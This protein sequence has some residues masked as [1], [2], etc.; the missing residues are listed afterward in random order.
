MQDSLIGQTL[1]RYKIEKLIDEGGMARVYLAWRA[2]MKQ[3]VALKVLKT[4][5][6]QNE[7]MVSRFIR[8]A[9]AMAQL[10]HQ[11][12][13]PV[14]DAARAKSRYY[15]AMAYL[16][17]QDLKTRLARQFQSAGYG[18]TMAEALSATG[19]AAAGL[20]YAHRRGLVHCDVKPS[21]FLL[22]EKGEVKITDFGI[23]QALGRLQPAQAAAH[24]TGTIPYMAPEQITNPNQ[25]D[26]RADIYALGVVLYELLAGRL[27]FSGDTDYGQLHDKIYETPL[28]LARLN[29]A[30]PGPIRKIVNKAIAK[31]PAKRYQSMAPMQ[32][33]LERARANLKPHQAALRPAA[34]GQGLARAVQAP[35]IISLPVKPTPPPAAKKPNYNLAI[36]LVGALISAGILW[37]LLKDVIGSPGGNTPG[38][39]AAISPT[40]TPPTLIVEPDETATSSPTAG[41]SATSRPTATR[42]PGRT[43]TRPAT[44]LPLATATRSGGPNTPTPGPDLADAPELVAPA[45]GETIYTGQPYEFR[46]RWPGQLPANTSFLVYIWPEGSPAQDMGAYDVQE[47]QSKI[48]PL[49]GGVYQISFDPASAAAVQKDQAEYRWSVAVVQ[50]TPYQQLG[51]AAESR[52]IVI[53]QTE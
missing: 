33:D 2:D 3:P 19:Q 51:P 52:R 17:G 15:L 11:N 29:P 25:A 6:S 1:G 24:I 43:P 7:R 50:V 21:N 22:T 40:G 37:F 14:F 10:Q 42:P 23:A 9:N 28:P 38:P 20:G 47:M 13:V 8:E 44:P 49:D 27:P 18:L 35:A 34:G 48:Q 30:V 36:I 5:F 12:I 26:H 32:A 4:E 45:N 41:P 39:V 16:P 31:E 46:W 53:G